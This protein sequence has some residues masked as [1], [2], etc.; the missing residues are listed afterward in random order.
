V[1]PLRE[2]QTLTPSLRAAREFLRKELANG[3]TEVT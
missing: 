1:G 2:K 3:V